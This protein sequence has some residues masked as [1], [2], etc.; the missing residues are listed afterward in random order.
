MLAFLLAGASFALLWATSFH[1]EYGYFIDELYY[2]ACAVRPAWGYVD[3]PPLS[4]LILGVSRRLLGTSLP[5]LRLAPALAGVATVVLTGALA[6]RL[7]ARAFGLVETGAETVSV[8]NSL[9][10]RV[11]EPR[12]RAQ[13]LTVMTSAS[14]GSGYAEQ[15]AV[16]VARIDASAIGREAAERSSRMQDPIELRQAETGLILGVAAQLAL[17]TDLV[18]SVAGREAVVALAS[19]VTVAYTARLWWG[20][21]KTAGKAP[22][23]R[24]AARRSALRSGPWR[25]DRAQST[26]RPSG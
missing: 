6:R 16:D 4:V 13:V 15:V 24:R 22:S 14:G 11:S 18:R 7:G 25:W 1:P 17:Q 10:V 2:L 19:I 26:A 3:H 21:S 8:V 23:A 5:A 20:A 9:G 12:S